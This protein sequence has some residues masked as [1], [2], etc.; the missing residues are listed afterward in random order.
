MLRFSM[1][2]A[3]AAGIAVLS[4][5]PEARAQ[6]SAG[7]LVESF[8]SMCTDTLAVRAAVRAAAGAGGWMPAP[9][10]MFPPDATI[11]NPEVWILSSREGMFFAFVS[12]IEYVEGG[13]VLPMRACA[14]G[15]GPKP[16]GFA[17]ALDRYA[18]GN[19]LTDFSDVPGE[20]AYGYQVVDGQARPAPAMSSIAMAR[21]LLN[22]QLHIVMGQEQED[23]GLIMY[24]VPEF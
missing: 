18:G 9:D 17:E 1:G 22:G 10:G 12:E 15:M 8:D 5:A 4:L 7:P 23:M 3:A 13:E 21:A 24:M 20:Y 14:V 6:T 11:K 16:E 2:L 19:R